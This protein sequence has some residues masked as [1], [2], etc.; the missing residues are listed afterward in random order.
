MNTTALNFLSREQMIEK[1]TAYMESKF[2][3]FGPCKE[4]YLNSVAILRRELGDEPVDQMLDALNRRCE[5]DILF[6]GNLGYQ[7]N[8]ANFRDPVARTFLDTD[9]EQYLRVNVL[10]GMPQRDTAEREIDAFYHT[11]SEEQKAAYE[12]ISSYMVYLELDLTKLAHYLGFMFANEMLY[13]TEPGY[14]SNYILTSAYSRS[15]EKW[16]GVEIESV[17]KHVFA[18][19]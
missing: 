4:E 9:F 18:A 16:Y 1:M 2:K 3:D 14:H 7:A 6:C 10:A 17:V 12:A 15:M 8:L 19:A 13:F 5:A 11:L